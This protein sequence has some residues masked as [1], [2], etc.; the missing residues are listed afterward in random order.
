M[1]GVPLGGAEADAFQRW[2]AESPDHVSAWTD[3]EVAWSLTGP[4]AAG[5]SAAVPARPQRRLAV[6]RAAAGLAATILIVAGGF[7]IAELRPARQNL[8]ASTLSTAPGEM[9]R[10]MLSDGSILVL[11]ADSALRVRMGRSD[12]RLDLTRG[13]AHFEVAHNDPRPFKVTAGSATVIAT[14]TSF[15][16]NCLPHAVDIILLHGGVDVLTPRGS[17]RLRPGEHVVAGAAGDLSPRPADTEAAAGWLQGR[18]SFHDESLADIAAQMNR[19]GGPRVVITDPTLA[20]IR[21]SGVFM[22][23]GGGALA[24]ALR[25]ARIAQPTSRPDGTIVIAA[26][27][28]R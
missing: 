3:T 14:G 1:G 28:S 19:Y 9:H 18:L 8:A 12:R 5:R 27:P 25:A 4:V 6:R 17:A 2:L 7:G 24:E 21:F 11:D 22:A 10:V 16:V 13:R 15:D 26:I 20:R 23:G